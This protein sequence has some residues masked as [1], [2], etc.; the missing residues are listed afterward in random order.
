MF[1]RDDPIIGEEVICKE[2]C[3]GN[4]YILLALTNYGGHV[5]YYE[6]VFGDG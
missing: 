4:P 2:T 3:S 5:G 1:A 6:N